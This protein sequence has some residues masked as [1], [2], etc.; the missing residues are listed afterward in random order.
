MYRI[1]VAGSGYVGTRAARYFRAK[2]QKVWGTTRNPEQAAALEREGITPVV[3]DFLV[4]ETLN[5]I[6]PVNFVVLS[7]APRERTDE[8]YR[9][10]YLKAAGNFLNTLKKNRRPDLLVYIS[11][12]GVYRDYAG[13]WVDETTPP[14]PDT[15][16]GD[17]LLEAENQVLGSGLPVVVFR[18][19]G[20]YGPGRNRVEGGKSDSRRVSK[21]SAAVTFSG[22]G[23]RWINMVHVEDVV[24]ALPAIFNKAEAGATYLGVDDC[25]VRE[26]EFEGWLARKSDS[27]LKAEKRVTVTFS[28]KR[29]IN[30]R[31]KLLGVRLKYPSFREGYGELLRT[32]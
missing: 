1:L 29:L 6:P 7:I 11:S 8:A 16:R 32:K 4:A 24:G 10:T 14:E 26:S 30:T 27:H 31:L 21:V 15:E 19:A 17:I 3:C 23:D 28:G 20:I 22:T 18:L 2:N 9:E 13:E 5:E 12:T 25:P